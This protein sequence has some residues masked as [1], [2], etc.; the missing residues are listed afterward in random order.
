MQDVIRLLRLMAFLLLL[1]LIPFAITLLTISSLPGEW[2]WWLAF[3]ALPLLPILF[4]L[5]PGLA[6]RV[7]ERHLP[8][9]L[10]LFI[11]VQA[12]ELTLRSGERLRNEFLV[13]TGH[14]PDQTFDAW[15]S[16]PFFFL[17][18]PAVLAAWAYGRKGARW[19][20]TWAGLLHVVGGVWL[21]YNEDPFSQ[22]YWTNMPVRLAI[23]YMVP[24]MVAYLASRQRQQHEALKDAHRQLQQ[25]AALSA[26]LAASRERNRLARDLHDT[27]AHS[28]AGLVVEL[29]AVSTLF[30][31]DAEAARGEL[32]KAQE[33]SRAGL[34]EAR[35]AIR[36]LRESPAQDL[37]LGPALRQLANDLSERTGLL[38][39]AEFVLSGP[40]PALP[41]E[42]ANA[43]YRIAQEALANVERHADATTVHLR[44]ETSDDAL[45]LTISDD[46]VGFEPGGATEGRY[47]LLGMRERADMMGTTLKVAS[48]PGAGS[49]IIV[50]LDLDS[51]ASQGSSRSKDGVKAF[52]EAFFDAARQDR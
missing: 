2:N 33:L 4:M 25:K 18:V 10:F 24:L 12:I 37:G 41:P 30:D 5:T 31:L 19:A 43:L 15:R 46:G 21:W 34:N 1:T 8:I 26:E 20:A 40:N 29:E 27:L 3:A 42:T 51:E 36:D 39:H 52:I 44:L 48:Q 6:R 32:K 45:R 38:T 14:S 22:G 28:L 50:E 11:T 17:L 47:G 7:G 49:Q 23:L 35:A 9:A 13:Q 16:E